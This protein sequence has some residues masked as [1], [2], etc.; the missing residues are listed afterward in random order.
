MSQPT[1]SSVQPVDLSLDAYS[2]YLSASLDSLASLWLQAAPKTN[3]LLQYD[4]LYALETHPPEGMSFQY[5]VLCD[6][7]Q[8][9]GVLYYQVF[10]L[11]V[12][13]SMQQ[14]APEIENKSHCIIKALSNAVKKWLIKRADFN[15]LIGGNLLLTGRFGAH[16]STDINQATQ[17][18]LMEQT[19]EVV[20]KNL[21]QAGTKVSVH[22]L[23]DYPTEAYAP[24]KGALKAQTYHPFEMQPCMY[25]PIRPHWETFENYLNDM[26]SK[27]RV[28]VRRARKKGQELTK[29]HFSLTEIEQNEERLYA[30]YKGIADGAGF[31]AFLLHPNY[32]SALKRSLGEHFQLVAYYLQDE[33]VAFYTTIHNHHEL[34]AHFLGVDNAH[35]RP[36]QIYLNILYDLVEAAINAGVERLDMARTALEIKSSVGAIP[37]EMMCFFKHRSTL[38]SKVLQLV[39]DSFNPKENWQPRSPFKK[40][41]AAKMG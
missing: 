17:A 31:N 41:K 4:Y 22:L 8:P 27:Y 29:R 32:F 15:L 6:H 30:L 33:L 11:N 40:E 13:A 7:G 2:I 9:V 37:E 5:A 23:K 38:S 35:N 24:L 20:Q 12:E 16:F 26:S 18:L 39:F 21:D 1:T 19:A 34:D 25:V 10:R 14:S 36:Y 28:R 3:R